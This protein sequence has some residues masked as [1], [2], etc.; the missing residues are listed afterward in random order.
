MKINVRSILKS[1]GLLLF[2]FFNMLGLGV[3]ALFMMPTVYLM[4]E[5]KMIDEFTY[6]LI[7]MIPLAMMVSFVIFVIA[8][9]SKSDRCS[10]CKE[11]K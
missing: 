1:I 5:A 10:V 9:I 8:M 7:G 6:R 2:V 11:K 4:L 3:I